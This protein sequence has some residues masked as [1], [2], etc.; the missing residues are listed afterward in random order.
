MNKQKTKTANALNIICGEGTFANGRGV[1]ST[2]Q[3]CYSPWTRCMTLSDGHE[4]QLK[5]GKNTNT[6]YKC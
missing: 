6:I 1:D 3:V 2:A 4:F 5:M